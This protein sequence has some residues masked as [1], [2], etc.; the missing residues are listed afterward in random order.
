MQSIRL[1]LVGALPAVQI[2]LGFVASSGL[3]ILR[4]VFS[5][6]AE[7]VVGTY[8]TT[9]AHLLPFVQIRLRLLLGPTAYAIRTIGLS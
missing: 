7:T 3:Q 4:P 8:R 5:A 6:E 9:I 1:E 2:G